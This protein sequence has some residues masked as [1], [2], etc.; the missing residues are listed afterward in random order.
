MRSP[1]CGII[2]F[3]ATRAIQNSL[4]T[5]RRNKMR[6][7]SSIGKAV[8]KMLT[9]GEQMFADYGETDKVAAYARVTLQDLGR[10]ATLLEDLEEARR[11]SC[12]DFHILHAIEQSYV[13]IFGFADDSSKL[14]EEIYEKYPYE[15]KEQ[16]YDIRRELLGVTSKLFWCVFYAKQRMRQ[17]SWFSADEERG[18]K[19][20]SDWN[21]R[22]AECGYFEQKQ[23]FKAFVKNLEEMI[24]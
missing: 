9:A 5:E 16:I 21:G 14:E 17:T 19:F 23:K 4:N 10:L 11:L 7:R 18:E 13:P 1:S 2:K 15:V 24:I 6:E 8:T 3:K 20:T 22:L 12:V